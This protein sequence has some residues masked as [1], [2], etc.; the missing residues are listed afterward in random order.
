ME[1]DISKLKIE[2]TKRLYKLHQAK[3]GG[4]NV[5]LA[6]ASGCSESTIRNIFAKLNDKDKGQDITLGMAFRLCH[7]LGVKLSDLVDG[8]EVK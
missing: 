7:A 3:F 5:H 8:L 2:I 4:N 1:K 6:K